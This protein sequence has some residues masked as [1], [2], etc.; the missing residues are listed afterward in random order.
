M[1]VKWIDIAADDPRSAAAL[2]N[3]CDQ[4]DRACVQACQH[5]GSGDVFR[6][7]DVLDR[8]QA[9]ELRVPF[10]VVERELG[11]L[12]DGRQRIELVDVEGLLGVAELAVLPL[13]D[14]DV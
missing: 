6:P 3:A 9:Q 14:G 7:V 12:M 2:Q 13:Q 8:H 5:A 1:H 4:F 10:V 11:Q